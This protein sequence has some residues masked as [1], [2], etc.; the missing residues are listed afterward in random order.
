MIIFS[1]LLF[2][3]FY[4]SITSQHFL[5]HLSFWLLFLC[6]PLKLWYSQ[7]SLIL[8]L[9]HFHSLGLHLPAKD[10][11]THDPG[12]DLSPSFPD[13]QNPFSPI[14]SWTPSP[15]RWSGPKHSYFHFIGKKM[16]RP[17]LKEQAGSPIVRWPPGQTGTRLLALCT[18]VWARRHNTGLSLSKGQARSSS[19]GPA[20]CTLEWLSP[21]MGYK[22]PHTNSLLFC[23]HKS[24]F[25]LDLSLAM[26]NLFAHEKLS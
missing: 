21:L 2:S 5:L 8:L 3:A 26:W 19:S 12:P 6:P 20:Q 10:S 22:A 14:I 11:H 17:T 18:G 13:P 4:G 9:V 7:N 16:L 1:D 15:W 23:P 25:L 24:W